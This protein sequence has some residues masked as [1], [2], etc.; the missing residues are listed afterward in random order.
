MHQIRYSFVS[1]ESE[2][3]LY[4][5]VFSFFLW[6][7]VGLFLLFLFAEEVRDWSMFSALPLL[8]CCFVLDVVFFP[9]FCDF[10]FS[11]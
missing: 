9:F 6:V 3:C 7:R 4:F 5:F 1:L 10:T 8:C 11:A 2:G